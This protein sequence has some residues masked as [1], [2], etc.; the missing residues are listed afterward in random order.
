MIDPRAKSNTA[1]YV[2]LGLQ[3]F[4]NADNCSPREPVLAGEVSGGW[5]SGARHKPAFKNGEA[6]FSV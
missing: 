5:Q 1:R 3:T 2:S 6:Q 4:E